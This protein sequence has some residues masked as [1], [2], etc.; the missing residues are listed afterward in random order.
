MI[1]LTHLEGNSGSDLYLRPGQIDMV[2]P[3]G[4]GSKVEVHGYRYTVAETPY[5]VLKLMAA[6]ADQHKHAPAADIVLE[7]QTIF[8]ASIDP[9][10]DEVVY[11]LVDI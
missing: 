4:A 8:F 2:K 10:D 3:A 11:N 1:K 6:W 7:V 5:T 9:E